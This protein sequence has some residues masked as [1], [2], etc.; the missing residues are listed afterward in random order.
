MR[1]CFIGDPRSIHTQRWVRWFAADHDVILIATNVDDA[2]GEFRVCTL[3]TTSARRGT[4]L[5]SSVRT[6]RRVLAAQRPDIVH[7]HFINEA[8]W[9]AAASRWRPS[10]ITAWGSDLYRAPAESRLAQ[11]LNP[12]AVRS[13]D[14]VT[15]DSVD[16]ARLLRSWGVEHERVS[17]IGW[18][19]DRREFHPDVDGRP[20]RA[21]LDIP[22]EAPVVL[23]PRQWLGNSNIEAV[24]AAHARLAADVYLLLKRQPRFEGEG[25]RSVHTAIEASPA[26]DRIRILEEIPAEELPTLYAAADAVVS[27]CVTDGTPVSVLEAM[28]LGRPVVALDNPSIAEWVSD[29]GGRLVSSPDAEQVADAIKSFLAAPAARERAAAHNLAVVAQR[30][31]RATEMTRMAGIYEQ[32]ARADAI[33]RGRRAG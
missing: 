27:L 33:K 6:V 11:R 9:F 4:R 23:S 3:P 8:G 28:A 31:D 7:A 1:L 12:W 26:R 32:L 15:C 16:Q 25:G 22:S 29:P 21:R 13:A 5:L 24:V 20:L 17:V 30:A 14:R 2:L 10:I 19:V 18:G